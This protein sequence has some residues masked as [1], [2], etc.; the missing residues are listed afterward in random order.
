MLNAQAQVAEA[1]RDLADVVF[2]RPTADAGK[3]QTKITP[4]GE[5]IVTL[6]ASASS[7][8]SGQKIVSY[9]WEK[10]V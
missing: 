2:I 9:L 7:A 4:T 8:A 5:A 3:D 6:D 1:A 10:E